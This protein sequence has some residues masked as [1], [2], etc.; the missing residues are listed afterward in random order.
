MADYIYPMGS[1]MV[2]VYVLRSKETIKGALYIDFQGFISEEPLKGPE[3][4]EIRWG[5]VRGIGREYMPETN[6]IYLV[7]L[8]CQY[9][10]TNDYSSV[11]SVHK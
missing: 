2:K 5:K 8:Y 7:R 4:V 11:E 9:I 10:N 3:E 6:N 1:S